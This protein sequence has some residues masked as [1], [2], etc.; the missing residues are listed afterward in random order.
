ME[1]EKQRNPFARVTL[2]FFAK[3]RE[4]VGES[5]VDFEF[6]L[7]PA[8]QG[9]EEYNSSRLQLTGGEL[10]DIVIGKYS[11][12]QPIRDNLIVAVNQ[13][14]I[15]GGDRLEIKGGEEIAI[16]PPISGG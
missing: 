12:L 16:I 1:G 11:A 13:E 10:L 15:E 6:E 9:Q 5:S 2:L 4:L 8:S 14:Y 7:P 3:S